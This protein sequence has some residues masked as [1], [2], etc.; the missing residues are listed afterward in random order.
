LTFTTLHAII[1]QKIEF[2][3]TTA[4]RISNPLLE[5]EVYSCKKERAFG[6]IQIPPRNSIT[7]FCITVT[8]LIPI[9]TGKKIGQ[10]SNFGFSTL[11]AW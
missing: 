10:V 9:H 4:V 8:V 6:M 3:I 7:V 11:R 5:I 2:F 1:F